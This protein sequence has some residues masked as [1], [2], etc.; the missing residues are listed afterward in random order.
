MGAFAASPYSVVPDLTH[1]SPGTHTLTAS[2]TNLYGTAWATPKVVTWNPPV[3]T[4]T[5]LTPVGS[6]LSA[7]EAIAAGVVS[8]YGNP[9]VTIRLDGT[10]IGTFTSAPYSVV[11]DLS[12]LLSGGH[13][14]SITAT[15]I[16]GSATLTKNVTWTPPVPTLV[17]TSPTV[18]FLTLLMPISVNV[19]SITS[20]T[21]TIAIDGVGHTFSKPPYSLMPDLNLLAE[22]THVLTATATNQYGSTTISKTVTWNPNGVSGFIPSDDTV[23]NDVPTAISSTN[24]N[25]ETDPDSWWRMGWGNSVTPDFVISP[26][27]PDQTG[28]GFIV[29]TLYGLD[30]TLTTK[31][32]VTQPLNY[33][34][35][36]RG[37]GTHL[38]STLDVMSTLADPP[39]GGWPTL[40]PGA[41][42]PEEG[43]WA[44]HFALFTSKGYGSGTWTVPFGIDRTPPRA[45]DGLK[46]S[47]TL[48]TADAGKWT[49]SSRA[50]VTWE[51][52]KYDSLSGV[53][54]YQ[55]LI[56]GSD[57][58]PGASADQGRVFE[59]PGVSPS[60]ITVEDMP[61]GKHKVSIVCVDRATNKSPA[62]STYFMSDPDVP[63]IQFGAFSPTVPAKPAISVVA[64][65]AG[66]VASVSYTLDGTPIGTATGAPY[67]LHPNLSHFSNGPHTLVATVKDMLGRTSSVSMTVTLDRTAPTIKSVSRSLKG[68]TLKLTFTLS[69]SATMRMVFGSLHTTH[70]YAHKGRYSLSLA[71]PR[72]ID[73]AYTTRLS[74]HSWSLSA[75]DAV[76]NVSTKSHGTASIVNYRFVQ[77]GP[78]SV[79]VIFR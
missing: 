31:I 73:N 69:K 2:A 77:T 15:N 17:W 5:L 34:R 33:F 62:A 53:A 14:L 42:R 40:M 24:P 58:I 1:L 8:D 51:P 52:A 13:V 66:G 47:P 46:A 38:D 21:V 74:K 37:T 27:S 23:L 12:H 9:T 32:D 71:Y 16:Y 26:P 11:P 41:Q 45:V 61:P 54:Y 79:K 57:V 76:G 50:H 63:T 60:S 64:S 55:V 44:F 29:G 59:V 75:T 70:F 35:T 4:I 20:P 25:D 18:S 49:S 7:T 19:S 68:G 39:A 72:A 3:P 6:S 78:N 22:G 28:V 43:Y 65:D 56:D 48:N 36:A 67:T 30:R 10:P